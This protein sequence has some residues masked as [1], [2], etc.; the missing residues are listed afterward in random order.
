MNSVRL[1]LY[2]CFLTILMSGCSESDV[3]KTFNISQVE[4][5]LAGDTF[6]SWERTTRIENGINV[7]FGACEDGNVLIFDQASSTNILYRIEEGAN[8]SSQLSTADTTINGSWEVQGNIDDIFTDTLIFTNSQRTLNPR[9][10]RGLTSKSL[11][12]FFIDDASGN[13]VVERY[14]F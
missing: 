11:D 2:M 14:S 6:K 12:L 7:D 3:S 1:F 8:C 13:E 4:R 5:L 9:V 10:L